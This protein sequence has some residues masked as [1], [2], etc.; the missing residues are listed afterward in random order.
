V[1]YQDA[2]FYEMKGLFVTPGGTWNGPQITTTTLGS[3]VNLQARI[4]NYSLKNYPSGS[5]LHVQ[6]YAQPWALG[7]FVAA[8]GNPNQFAAA[9]FIGIGTTQSGGTLSP[10]P[11]FCGG[12]PADGSDPCTSSPGSATNNWE[13]AYA[14]WDTS[15]GGVAANSTWKFW[16]V[17]WVTD[18]DGNLVTELSG[19]GLTSLPAANVKYNSLADV[20]IETYSNNLGFYNQPFTVLPVTPSTSVVVAAQTVTPATK[21]LKVGKASTR[22]NAAI[23]RNVPITILAT[24]VASGDHVDSILTEY[25][26]GDPAKGGTLFDTQRISR[27]MPGTPYIDTASFTAKTCGLHRIFVRS[28]PL[29]GTA[30]VS[31]SNP[32]FRVTSDPVSSIDDLITYVNS[33]AYPARFRRAML[34]YLNAAKRSFN[35]HRTLEGTI[36]V[37]VLLELVRGGTFFVPSNVQKA[38]ADQMKDLLGCLAQ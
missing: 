2:S 34:A 21:E 22:N 8:S 7:Q 28:I 31:S 16:V 24:H 10:P 9:V 36:Q 4:Y 15:Q 38:L 20:P 18:T 32:S 14:T 5:T 26:D 1:G 17:A 27:V 30:A 23:Q 19:Q 37:Q 29:D 25:Y 11:A 6:F 35:N 3:T 12:A 33:P 13:Y